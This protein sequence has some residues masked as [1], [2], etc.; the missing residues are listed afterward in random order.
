MRCASCQ[1]ENEPGRKFCVECGTRLVVA[2]P[3]CGS[4]NSPIRKVC[5]ECGTPLKGGAEG[6][7][8]LAASDS[9]GTRA[10]ARAL[11]RCVVSTLFA[12]LV[13]FTAQSQERDPEEV[14][15]APE[16]LLRGGMRHVRTLRRNREKFVGDPVMA[17]VPGIA[18]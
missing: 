12:H 18:G 8:A 10:G 17:V 7:L 9:E 6:A 5:G 13:G 14:Q 4:A 11:E 2:C 1:T 3:P 15:R 16:P